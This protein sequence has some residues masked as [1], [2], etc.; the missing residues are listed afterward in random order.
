MVPSCFSEPGL[1]FIVTNI[2]PNKDL[3]KNMIIT[4]MS[5]LVKGVAQFISNPS[6]SGEIAEIH[7]DSVTLRPPHDYVDEDSKKN[8]ENFWSLGYA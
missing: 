1:T 4:P 5:T 3:F 2:A 8:L 6:L 7:G